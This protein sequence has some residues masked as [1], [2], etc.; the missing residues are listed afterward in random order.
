MPGLNFGPDNKEN[1][2]QY[3]IL[4]LQSLQGMKI[5]KCES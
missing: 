4:Y 5:D 3:L 1:Y 2:C